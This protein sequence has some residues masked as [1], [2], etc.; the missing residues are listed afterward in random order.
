MDPEKETRADAK[1]QTIAE[2]DDQFA[3]DMW[4]FRYPEKGGK[5]LTFAAILVE[6]PLRC[7]FTVSLSSLSNFY[8]WLKLRRR[9]QE[10]QR[11]IEQIKAELARDPEISEEQVEK[12]GRVMFMTEGIVE[13]DAKVFGNMVKIG[14]GRVKL[15]QND[16]LIDQK[17]KT[18]KQKDKVISQGERRVRLLEEAAAEAKAKILA[19]TTSAKSAGGLTPETLKQIEE[20]AGLL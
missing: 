4:R 18:I 13:K 17:D 15:D 1:L 5:K 8:A 10:K 3:E 12:A 19:L 9:F 16:K 11:T 7:G 2:Q 20:A 14:H 6:V